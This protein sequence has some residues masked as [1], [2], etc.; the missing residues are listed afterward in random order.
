MC[1]SCQFI[2]EKDAFQYVPLSH[3]SAKSEEEKN[4][5]ASPRKVNSILK[6]TNT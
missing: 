6:T 1:N 4:N 3:L 5:R 2:V